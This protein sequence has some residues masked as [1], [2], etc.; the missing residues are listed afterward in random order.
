MGPYLQ[1]RWL[2]L[3][4]D[5]PKNDSSAHLQRYDAPNSVVVYRNEV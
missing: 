5:C 4:L 3:C 2:E 1:I